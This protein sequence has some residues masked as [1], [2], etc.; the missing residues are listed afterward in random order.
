MSLHAK[1]IFADLDSTARPAVKGSTGLTNAIRNLGTE[2]DLGTIV[3][4]Q[5]RE[6]TEPD[7][8]PQ[9]CRSESEAIIN[10]FPC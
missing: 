10:R 5:I 1:D 2:V 9:I 4:D 7:S 6:T 3:P 8:Q